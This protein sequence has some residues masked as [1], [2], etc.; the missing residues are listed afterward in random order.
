MD[1]KYL[2]LSCFFSTK[3]IVLSLAKKD[4]GEMTVI[5]GEGRGKRHKDIEI[6]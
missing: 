3:S 2:L 6:T 1:K 5:Y 4:D